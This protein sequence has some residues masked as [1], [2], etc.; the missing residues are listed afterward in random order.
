MYLEPR[1]RPSHHSRHAEVAAPFMRD[2]GALRE[3]D[4]LRVNG[5]GAGTHR[6]ME[7]RYRDHRGGRDKDWGSGDFDEEES[8][9]DRREHAKHVRLN[10]RPVNRHEPRGGL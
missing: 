6:E 7:N 8:H 10:S 2:T 3:R 9:R 1:A 5:E 4:R